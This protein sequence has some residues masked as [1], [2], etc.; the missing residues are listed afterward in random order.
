[1]S[2]SGLISTGLDALSSAVPHNR[3]SLKLNELNITESISVDAVA[4][5]EQLNQP[6]RYIITFTS[7]NPNRELITQW[8]ESDLVFIQRLLAD[9]GISLAI[10]MFMVV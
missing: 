9:V 5:D 1:M 2:F 8:Q 7:C 10:W 4:I 3:Y 6:W